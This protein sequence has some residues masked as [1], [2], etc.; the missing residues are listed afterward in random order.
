MKK[1]LI[2]KLKS[3]RQLFVSKSLP[4]GAE[5]WLKSEKYAYEDCCLQNFFE[6]DEITV[7]RGHFCNGYTQ[8]IKDFVNNNYNG[9]G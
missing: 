9:I 3:L 6:Q 1:Y 4:T 7:N 2:E 8:A 5:L